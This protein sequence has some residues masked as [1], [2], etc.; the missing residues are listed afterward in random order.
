MA[1]Y[2]NQKKINPGSLIRH[3][4][5]IRACFSLLIHYINLM[6]KE[7]AEKIRQLEFKITFSKTNLIYLAGE[8]DSEKKE[9]LI[10]FNK[11]E[12][13]KAKAEIERLKSLDFSSI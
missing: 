6:K 1:E 5:R 9:S 3:K 12:I 13:E 10:S 2:Q 8:P 11:S 7:I 4:V